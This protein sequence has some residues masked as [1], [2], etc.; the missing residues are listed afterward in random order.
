MEVAQVAVEGDA[1]EGAFVGDGIDKHAQLGAACLDRAAGVDG[2]WVEA[3]GLAQEGTQE[4]AF[5]LDWRGCA[6]RQDARGI[7]HGDQPRA[8]SAAAGG[9]EGVI[10][11]DDFTGKRAIRPI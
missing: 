3:T 11:D 4:A 5:G 1:G 8:E 2:V 10:I 6:G 9:G 7:G